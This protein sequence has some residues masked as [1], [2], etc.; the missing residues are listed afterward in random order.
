MNVRDADPHGIKESNE[1]TSVDGSKF[2]KYQIVTPDEMSCKALAP[3]TSR[4]RKLLFLGLCD[5]PDHPAS[6]GTGAGSRPGLQAY[7]EG[8]S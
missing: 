4:V 1:I 3:L 5:L 7:D 8:R 6:P 2:V